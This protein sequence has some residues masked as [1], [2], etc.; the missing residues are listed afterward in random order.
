META[1]AGRRKVQYPSRDDQGG[2]WWEMRDFRH[3]RWQGKPVQAIAIAERV[4]AHHLIAKSRLE[5]GS[6]DRLSNVLTCQVTQLCWSA[7]QVR[8]EHKEC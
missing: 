1:G 2:I 7:S 5:S 8:L 3:F 4:T 6:E